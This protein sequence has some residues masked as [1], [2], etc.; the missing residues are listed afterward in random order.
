MTLEQVRAAV[1]ADQ[2]GRVGILGG[3]DELDLPVAQVLQLFE[4]ETRPQESIRQQLQHELLITGQ[5]LAAYGDGFRA[6][7]S[8]ECP[9]NAFNGV[10]EGEGVTLACAFFQQTCDQ[11]RYTGLAGGRG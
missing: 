8:V 5:E 1:G 9:A 10:Y 6:G 7:G 3:F 11:G 2:L 4:L